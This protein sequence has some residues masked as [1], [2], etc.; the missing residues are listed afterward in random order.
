MQHTQELEFIESRLEDIF[1]IQKQQ[2]IK[3]R[4]STASQR[5]ALLKRLLDWINK[6]QEEIR[7]AVHADYRKP[8][9]EI[10]VTEIFPVSIE[11]NHAIK[12]LEHWMKPKKVGS[13]LI[14]FG[15]K[16]YIQYEP[17]GVCLIIAPWNYA[18]NLAVGP[19]V[20]AIAAGCPVTIKP[21]E[22]TPHTSALLRRMMAEIFDTHTVTVIEGG[23]EVSQM[24]L[25]KPFD[26]IF[27]TGSPAVGKIVMKA[28]A[29]HLTS[30]TLELGGKSPVLLLDDADLKDTADKITATKFLNC[31]QTCIAPDY[32]LVPERLKEA[33][34]AEL[35]NS[36]EKMYG[37]NKS[38]IEGSK[39]Y[40]RI[41]NENHFKRLQHI[42]AD[43]SLKGAKLEFGG[44][45]NGME[46]FIEPTIMSE[47]T[48][49]MKVLQEE[50]FGP[51]LPLVSYENVDDAINIV[52]Q[53]PKPLAFYVFSKNDNQ[54]NTVFNATSSGAAV[55]ND[56]AVHFLHREL[57]FGGVNN[58]GIG[59]SHGH[60][61]F[62]AFSNEKAVLRQRVGSA[63]VN[64]LF[65]PFTLAKK[66]LIKGILKWL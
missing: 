60:F 31:G 16:A 15:T 28:A 63:A 49:D 40:S 25:S 43:A 19:L 65:P 21:S 2:A 59:K 53:Q 55:A 14:F 41:V 57:P 6:N 62:L 9:P 5:I 24:L 46:N 22:M 23:V 48:W 8:Y 17:K 20:S 30:V 64:P 10:D 36:I 47:V 18:F 52:N 45:A 32:V 38:G 39:D 27:F 44:N 58:S 11:I 13:P 50:I 37:S 1:L 33:F 34:V 66:K 35:K 56:C 12:N 42:I 29:E 61:G 4:N 51:I 26:H 3:L 7:K 54:I